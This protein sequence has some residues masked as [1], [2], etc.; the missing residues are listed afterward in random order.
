MY[1]SGDVEN[2]DIDTIDYMED[3]VVDW[4]AELVSL[5]SHPILGPL[6]YALQCTPPAP[7]R[8]NP[9][10]PL[11]T[12]RLDYNIIRH[13]LSRPSMRKYLDRFEYM[14]YKAVDMRT[15]RRVARGDFEPA[16]QKD[17]DGQLEQGFLDAEDSGKHGPAPM[18]RKRRN[19]RVGPHAQS[20]SGSQHDR[21][22]AGETDASGS[23]KRKPGP[24]KGWKAGLGEEGQKG[25]KIKRAR[26]STGASASSG[27]GSS[28]K[29]EE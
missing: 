23:G 19:Q 13:R 7:M 6:S 26:Q 21:G 29:A 8:A 16:N 25:R 24:K 20:Q 22:L 1:A 10:A 9:S 11:L 18:K 27:R 3:L 2:P 15:A 14:E 4:L 17:L 5:L 12:P 28:V